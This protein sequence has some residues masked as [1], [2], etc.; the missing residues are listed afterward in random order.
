MLILIAPLTA[1]GQVFM[2]ISN[3]VLWASFYGK[4][5]RRFVI[6][7]ERPKLGFYDELIEISLM[8]KLK[9]VIF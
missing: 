2:T 9:I 7:I 1:S 5:T 6:L 3:L 4:S 8:E